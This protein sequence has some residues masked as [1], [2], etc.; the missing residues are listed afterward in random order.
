MNTVCIQ[1]SAKLCLM[2]GWTWNSLAEKGFIHVDFIRVWFLS[3]EFYWWSLSLLRMLKPY[4]FPKSHGKGGINQET[5]K[6]LPCETSGGGSSNIPGISNG[7]GALMT[8]ELPI[9]LKL[10]YW[11]LCRGKRILINRVFVWW[12]ALLPFPFY[13]PHQ[14]VLSYLETFLPWVSLST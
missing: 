6:H 13:S 5:R 2:Q 9:A 11:G 4:T 12:F 10:P 7:S 8:M 14:I 1:L 3:W